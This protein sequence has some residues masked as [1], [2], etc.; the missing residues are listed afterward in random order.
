SASIVSSGSSSS[1][2]TRTSS[3]STSTGTPSPSTGTTPATAGTTR[4][5]D[6]DPAI[7]YTGGNGWHQNSN[8]MYSGGTATGSGDAGARATLTFSGTGVT[9]IGYEDEYAGT[10]NIYVDGTKQATVDMYATPFK[11]QANVYSVSG[12]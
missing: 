8:S 5:E 10:A 4:I 2:S 9:F 11:A 3:S 1:A 6:T 7:A 12:L